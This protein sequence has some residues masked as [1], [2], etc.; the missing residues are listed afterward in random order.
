M[1]VFGAPLALED[2]APR[3]CR[4]ALEVHS[5]I[6]GLT[7][8]VSRRNGVELQLRIGLNSGR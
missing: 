5:G 7:Q 6:G 3:A 8:E 2:H 1:A 4:A